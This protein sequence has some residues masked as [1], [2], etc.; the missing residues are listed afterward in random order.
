MAYS[1]ARPKPITVSAFGMAGP[2]RA[3]TIATFG[4]F[5]HQSDFHL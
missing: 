5:E 1:G 2:V 4:L 3:L